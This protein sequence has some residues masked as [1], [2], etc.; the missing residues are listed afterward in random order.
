M[1]PRLDCLKVTPDYGRAMLDLERYIGECG[2]VRRPGKTWRRGTMLVDELY[3]QSVIR[4]REKEVRTL[5]LLRAWGSP[6]REPLRVRLGKRLVTLGR[7]LQGAEALPP[8]TC[9]AS[10][11]GDSC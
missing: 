1:K 6:I 8:A 10:A 3:A 11:H 9:T 7:W 2:K 5:D 4:E